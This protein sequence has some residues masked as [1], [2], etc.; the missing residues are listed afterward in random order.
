MEIVEEPKSKYRTST[1]IGVGAL[2]FGMILGMGVVLGISDDDCAHPLRMWMIVL[3]SVFCVHV[4]FLILAETVFDRT[5]SNRTFLGQ[6]YLSVNCLVNAFVFVWIVLGNSYFY[7]CSDS[8]SSDWYAGYVMILL[9][10]VTYY[11]I[12]GLLFILLVGLLV[13]LC[14]GS[15][16]INKYKK[17]YDQD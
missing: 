11:I 7:D 15:Y 2:E 9:I 10:F 12:A 3:L 5:V 13:V 16:H 8:C 6:A 17:Q 4:V 1:A 14:I